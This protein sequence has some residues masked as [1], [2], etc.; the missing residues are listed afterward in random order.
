MA[1]VAVMM[2]DVIAMTVAVTTTTTTSSITF[3]RLPTHRDTDL[4]EAMAAIQGAE[5][6][7]ATGEETTHP[8]REISK[9][10]A[11]ENSLTKPCDDA[12]FNAPRGTHLERGTRNQSR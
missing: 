3:G 1:M 11:P 5:A 9:S 7:A 4:E 8:M 10:P 2:G 6:E 12:D